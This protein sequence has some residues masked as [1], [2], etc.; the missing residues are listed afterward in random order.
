[1]VPSL[2]L[3]ATRQTNG[4]VVALIVSLNCPSKATRTGEAVLLDGQDVALVRA[5]VVDASGQVV[6]MAIVILD[7]YKETETDSAS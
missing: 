4:K 2:P 6:H 7:D 5:A 1:M 3:A